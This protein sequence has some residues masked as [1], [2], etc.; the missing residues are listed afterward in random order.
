MTWCHLHF[1]HGRFII[2]NIPNGGNYL[3]DIFAMYFL[4]ILKSCNHVVNK[5]LRHFI[6]QLDAIVIGIY[7]Y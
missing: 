3:E 5:L 6:P 7:R 1:Y 4:A 2:D